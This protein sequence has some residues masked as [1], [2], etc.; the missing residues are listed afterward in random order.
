MFHTLAA[1]GRVRATGAQAVRAVE[2]TYAGSKCTICNS[3]VMKL[4]RMCMCEDKARPG[5]FAF[6]LPGCKTSRQNPNKLVLALPI[7]M[8]PPLFNQA[9]RK[10][11]RQ[12]N[13]YV[14]AVHAVILCLLYDVVGGVVCL[15]QLY[16]L[17]AQKIFNWFLL[18]RDTF[19]Q[20][21]SKWVNNHICEFLCLCR[22][23]PM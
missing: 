23:I 6:C 9:G 21:L 10:S 7:E 20:F 14:L 12:L 8:V 18:F 16:G 22:W 13:F 3:N 2:P 11:A 15:L 17:H 1:L 5:S 19:W 4:T